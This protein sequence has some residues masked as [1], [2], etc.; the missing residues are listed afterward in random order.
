[1]FYLKGSIRGCEIQGQDQKSTYLSEIYNATRQGEGVIIKAH[2][3]TSD[4]QRK[5]DILEKIASIESEHL[6]QPLDFG[7]EQI[8]DQEVL[9]EIYR[10]VKDPLLTELGLY[11]DK[12]KI[13]GAVVTPISTGLLMGLSALHK[14]GL[15]HHD[16]KENNIFVDRWASAR[17]FDYGETTEPYYLKEGVDTWNQVPPEYRK[18]KRKIDFT[19]DIWQ[20]G[21]VL[22]ALTSKVKETDEE[23]EKV[24]KKLEEFLKKAKDPRKTKRFQNGNQMLKALFKALYK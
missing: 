8:E 5:L 7:V 15:I 20:A 9:I 17:L 16:V 24:A 14:A 10:K 2:K 12:A 11:F 6:V 21:N 3:A 13:P 22:E 18:G 23:G 4:T 19:F 1:M